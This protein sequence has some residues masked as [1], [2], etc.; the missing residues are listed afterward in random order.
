MSSSNE[1]SWMI[2][3]TTVGKSLLLLYL[4]AFIGVLIPVFGL[5]FDDPTLL[6]PFPEAVTWTYLWYGVMNIVLILTYLYLF[7]PWA[8]EATEYVDAWGHQGERESQ[9]PSGTT[10]SS[11]TPQDGGDA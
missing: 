5:A 7:R 2:P 8:E 6:G 1:G 4:I 3:R 10:A 9:R 11:A